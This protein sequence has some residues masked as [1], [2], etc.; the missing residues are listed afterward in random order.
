MNYP[1]PTA[2]G[3]APHTIDIAFVFD[4]LTLSPGMVGGSDAHIK[5]AQPLATM[6]SEA[7]IRY[8]ATGDPNGAGMPKWPVYSL[9]DRET[10]LFDKVSKT[11]NDPRGEERRMMAGAKYRQPGT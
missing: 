5:A 11:A 2:D 1:S 3:R 4:N 6:M 10:M 8:A 9:K 7:L